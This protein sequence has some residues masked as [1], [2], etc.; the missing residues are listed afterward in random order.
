MKIY[1]HVEHMI[2]YVRDLL[3]RC[4][5]SGQTLPSSWPGAELAGPSAGMASRLR[6]AAREPV[7]PLAKAKAKNKQSI[8]KPKFEESVRID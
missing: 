3:R 5:K 8:T 1:Q 6:T 4:E 7:F 2:K